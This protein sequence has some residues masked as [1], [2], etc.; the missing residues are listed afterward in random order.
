MSLTKRRRAATWSSGKLHPK[1]HRAGRALG[2]SRSVPRLTPVYATVDSGHQALHPQAATEAVPRS[3][4]IQRLN[5]EA[6]R[7]LT[8]VSAPA[9]FG[10]TTL[11][12]EWVQSLGETFP[13]GAI[14]WLSLDEA[15]SDPLRFLTY[16]VAALQTVDASIGQGALGLLQ[17]PH[18]HPPK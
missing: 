14:A 1:S 15:D 18:P 5:E 12:S 11:V 2:L 4:L 3:R 16:I 17:S 7:K 9:G 8:L 6:P 13:P 10:K